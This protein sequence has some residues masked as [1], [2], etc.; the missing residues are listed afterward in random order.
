MEAN[1]SR[2]KSLL[3]LESN[4]TDTQVLALYHAG[5]IPYVTASVAEEAEAIRQRLPKK[6][7]RHYNAQVMLKAIREDLIVMTDDGHLRWNH[8]SSTLLA[9][10][11]GRMWC[12]DKAVCCRHGSR[13]IWKRGNR[14]FLETELELL[15]GVPHLRQLREK[16]FFLTIPN[17]AQ[18]IDSL[19][20]T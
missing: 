3:P 20:F 8:E 16:R 12:G 6:L 2:K 19:F 11:C 14:P 9:Y 10:F 5:R 4:L 13:K 17:D 1:N 18:L 15:F 7:R